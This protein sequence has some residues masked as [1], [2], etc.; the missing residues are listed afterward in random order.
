[1]YTRPGLG[2]VEDKVA[3]FGGIAEAL[4][5]RKVAVVVYVKEAVHLRQVYGFLCGAL[6]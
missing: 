4:R 6:S 1:M 2:T 5:V 3:F